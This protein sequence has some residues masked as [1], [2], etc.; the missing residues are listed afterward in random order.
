MTFENFAY[1]CQGYAEIC[2]D[3][4][5]AEQWGIIKEHLQLC[6]NKVTKVR[7]KPVDMNGFPQCGSVSSTYNSNKLCD[8]GQGDKDGFIK[9]NYEQWPPKIG[10]R[11]WSHPTKDGVPLLWSEYDNM[12]EADKLNCVINHCASC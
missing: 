5:T 6:F 9:I 11:N 10:P 12:T 7:D 2:G 3:V 1:W 8:A 4:P